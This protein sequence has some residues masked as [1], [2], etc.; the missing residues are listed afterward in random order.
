M[1][2]AILA[3]KAATAATLQALMATFYRL[4]FRYARYFS[5]YMRTYLCACSCRGSL[6][7]CQRLQAESLCRQLSCTF[8]RRIQAWLLET[9][10]SFQVGTNQTRLWHRMLG[11][12]WEWSKLQQTA[13]PIDCFWWNFP[14][15]SPSAWHLSFGSYS[16]RQCFLG[17][18]GYPLFLDDPRIC[19][20]SESAQCE[21]HFPKN[22]SFWDFSG[23]ILKAWFQIGWCSASCRD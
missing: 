2:L 4:Y 7:S 11:E 9:W 14:I 3:P 5:S 12:N 16:K 17:P 13:R 1:H 10:W 20:N 8:W 15:L 6:V 22:R 21:K 23:G 19:Q 18:Q